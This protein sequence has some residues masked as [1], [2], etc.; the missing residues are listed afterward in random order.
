MS[1][2]FVPKGILIFTRLL[3]AQPLAS[4]IG[5]SVRW[6]SLS[7]AMMTAGSEIAR[8]TPSNTSG[9]CQR[10]SSASLALTVASASFTGRTGFNVASAASVNTT[11]MSVTFDAPPNAAQAT[12]L[13][14]YSVPG[15]ALSGTLSFL[16]NCGLMKFLG[17][18]QQG[19]PTEGGENAFLFYSL[20]DEGRAYLGQDTAR[21]VV[22]DQADRSEFRREGESGLPQAPLGA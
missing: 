10:W 22:L 16:S 21:P 19:Q 20:T 15:L 13:A 9:T 1:V 6:R 12:T 4:R 8:T 5:P 11:T 2:S 18:L 17:R 14:S 7:Q 3:M